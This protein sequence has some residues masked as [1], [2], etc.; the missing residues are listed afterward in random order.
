MT[1]TPAIT[2]TSGAAVVSRIPPKK[3]QGSIQKVLCSLSLPA[4]LPASAELSDPITKRTKIAPTA[5]WLS[6]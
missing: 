3:M 1:A 6:L 5:A 2:R 4:I